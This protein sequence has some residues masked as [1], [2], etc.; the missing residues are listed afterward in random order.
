[1]AVSE[2][3]TKVKGW[4]AR[5]RTIAECAAA[6]D[7]DGLISPQ[8][9]SATDTPKAQAKQG[10]EA[11]VRKVQPVDKSQSL[12]KLQDGFNQLIEKLQGINEHLNRQVTQ[13]EELTRR[14]DELPRLLETLPAVVQNQKQTTD[15]LVEQLKGFA[16]RNQQSIDAVE[17]IPAETVK[18]TDALTDI[19]HQLSAAAETD[20]AMRESFNQ[21]K[22]TLEK[23]NQT[24]GGQTDS[25]TQMSKTFATSDRYMKYLVS[26]QSRRFIWVFWTAIG[27]CIFAIFSLVVIVA[28]SMKQ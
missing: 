22:N 25:I 15:Q 8:Q 20:V 14:I 27:V 17:K 4:V 6:I 26:K 11:M 24:T 19:T 2:L 3:L 23:L 18:Q 28:I 13:Q 16:L 9:D 7:E 5:E 10:S 21:F 1:M 12:E